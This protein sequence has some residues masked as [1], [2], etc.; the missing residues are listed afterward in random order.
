MNGWSEATPFFGFDS[1]TGKIIYT[2]D[3]I[4]SLNRVIR[5]S[6][7]MRSSFPTDGAAAKLI[8]LAIRKSKRAAEMSGNGLQ[9]ATSSP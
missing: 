2:T 6:I 7:R 4:E 3:A 8:Y 5:K 9:P 1:A